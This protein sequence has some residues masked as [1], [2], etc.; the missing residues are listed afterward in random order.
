M[1][2]KTASDSGVTM[3]AEQFLLYLQEHRYTNIVLPEGL[4]VTE[5]VRLPKVEFRGSF[6]CGNAVF[7]GF[8]C[9]QARFRESFDCSRATFES[10][11]MFCCGAA[12]FEK[13]FLCRVATFCGSFDCSEATF[14]G[15]FSCGGAHFAESFQC[16]ESIF[17]TSF[18][19]GSALF[20]GDFNCGEADFK[21]RIYAESNPHIAW[22]IQQAK[23]GVIYGL[24]DVP[25]WLQP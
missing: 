16:N 20:D 12:V 11:F 24:D 18:S 1:S 7:V 6:N 22:L 23:Q 15:G 17:E 2:E 8:E 13:D 10:G 9:G 3:N 4:R 21:G 14:Q 5:W 19:C 25:P